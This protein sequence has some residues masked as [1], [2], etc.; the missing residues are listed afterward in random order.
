MTLNWKFD[1]TAVEP[2]QMAGLPAGPWATVVPKPEY[3]DN[4]QL[5]Q[6][7]AI[8]LAKGL[9][10]FDA[11]LIIFDGDASKALWVSVHWVK[12]ISVVAYRDMYIS[13]Q[14][15]VE[16]PL[17]KEALL[18][19]LLTFADER[20]NHGRPVVEAKDRL[21][22]LRLYSD[23]LGFTGKTNIDASTTNNSFA[24][25]TV[26]LVMVKPDTKTIDHAPNIKSEMQNE[27]EP[28][29]KL[30]LVGGNSAA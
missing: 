10:P 23:I 9:Q 14:K 22:A 6:S 2:Q 13:A 5:K 19:K 4:D 27:N 8:E 21:G 17:D 25:K 16:K 12:D 30:K 15:A 1:A 29:I 20:D 24:N 3:A 26:N 7:F 18:A 11:G 28:L